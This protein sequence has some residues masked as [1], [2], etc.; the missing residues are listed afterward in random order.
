MMK[1][2]DYYYQ[3]HLY[4]LFI[5]ELF[6]VKE[7]NVFLSTVLG[8]CIAV[9]LADKKSGVV[10]M[11]HFMLP[12]ASG[13]NDARYGFDSMTRLLDEMV[14]KG[15]NLKRLTAKIFGGARML[16]SANINVADSNIAFVEDYLT[17]QRISV[18]ASDMGSCY[19]RR[20]HFCST[21]HEVHVKKFG[22][23][24]C[25]DQVKERYIVL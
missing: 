11:N 23:K 17:Q 12:G 20:V 21:S 19:G 10:G 1:R 16:T 9:C 8:P 24:P 15:A 18:E 22:K 5:G 13:C 6:V 4:E 7:E 3:K 14:K 2:F 25:I